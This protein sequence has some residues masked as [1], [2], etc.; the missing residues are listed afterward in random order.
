MDLSTGEHPTIREW[1]LRNSPC[2]WHVPI[3][4]ALEKAGGS[5]KTSAGRSSATRSSSRR[6]GRGLLHDPRRRTV[7]YIPLTVSRVTGIVCARID[8]GEGCLAHHRESFLYEHFEEICAICVPTMSASRR[9][10]CGRAPSPMP[11]TPRSSPSSRPSGAD[12]RG[13]QHDCQVMI[14]GPATCRCTRSRRTW[15]K[16]LATCGEAPF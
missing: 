12:A 6:A 1:I 8:H 9:T 11:T 4:Q 3:Y 7:P 14:E 10:V 2:D 5:P 13:W 16:Q 15:T